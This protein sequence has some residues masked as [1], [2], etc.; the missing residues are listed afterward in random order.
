MVVGITGGIACGKSRVGKVFE[1]M[2]AKIIEA[3]EIGW[4]ILEEREIKERISEVFGES[5][6]NTDGKIDRKR[7]GDFLFDQRERL[8][9]FN[10]IVR[11]LLLNKL[12]KRIEESK[13]AKIVAV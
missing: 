4:V 2:G 3:D 5:F 9:K 7:L 12:K 13:D 10:A 1:R 8:E 6:L 11:P